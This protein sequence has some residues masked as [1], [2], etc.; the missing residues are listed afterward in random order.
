MSELKNTT[1]TEEQK[2]YMCFKSKLLNKYFDSWDELKKEETAYLEEQKKKED[3]KL[4]RKADAAAVQKAFEQ[5][6]AAAEVYNKKLLEAEKVRREEI[7]KI[8]AAYRESIKESLSAFTNAQNA[9]NQALADFQKAHPEGY[10]LTLKDGNNEV[11]I[12]KDA[13][14]DIFTESIKD[15][16][17]LS[18]IFADFWK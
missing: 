16:A 5:K 8:N 4:A 2:D 14:K 9:Y 18:D 17:R 1:L 12:R 10:H 7:E 13:Y 11:N 15:L 3:A 6:N